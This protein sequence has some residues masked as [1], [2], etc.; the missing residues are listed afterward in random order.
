MPLH[1]VTYFAMFLGSA[2]LTALAVGPA[3]ADDVPEPQTVRLI[4]DYGDGVQKHFT[5]LE[6]KDGMTVL[7]AMKEAQKHPRG[8]KFVHRGKGE[9]AFLTRIDELE[10]EGRGRNWMYRVNGELAKKSFAILTVKAADTIL[11]T[12]GEYR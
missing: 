5:A 10:N 6:W 1:A 11:W 2:V 8:M 7:D 12:F 3:C 4:I 9:T